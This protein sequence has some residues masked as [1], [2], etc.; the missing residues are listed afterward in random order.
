MA[1]GRGSVSHTDDAS[2]DR[3]RR[4]AQLLSER[5]DKYGGGAR[6]SVGRVE[7]GRGEPMSSRRR[8]VSPRDDAATIRSE[9]EALK[10]Q[11]AVGDGPHA[12]AVGTATRAQAGEDATL[13]FDQLTPTE[14]SAASLGVHPDEWK[15]ISFMVRVARPARLRSSSSHASTRVRRTTSTSKRSRRTTRSTTVSCEGSRPFAPSRRRV[16]RSPARRPRPSARAM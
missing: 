3:D 10:S 11:H 4:R 7:A 5:G 12:A 16:P 15:P 2:S 8:S 13:T 14:Q 6:L 9:L 1:L